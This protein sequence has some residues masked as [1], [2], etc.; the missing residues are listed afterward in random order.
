MYKKIFVLIF[1]LLISV[2]SLI[3]VQ[4]VVL[5]ENFTATWCPYCPSAYLGLANLK[6]QVRDSVTILAYHRS[7]AFTVPEVNVRYSYYSCTG[8]PT[9]LFDGVLRRVGGYSNQNQPMYYRDLYDSRQSVPAPIE[10]TL[11]RT[12]FNPFSGN[13]AVSVTINNVST[14]IIEGNL[15]CV[16]V[17]KETTYAWQN[18]SKL[19]DVVLGMFPNN[20]NGE[21]LSLN[22]GEQLLRSYNYSIPTA[23]REMSCAIVAFLQNNT[24]KE[25]YNACEVEARAGIE[26]THQELI[27]INTISFTNPVSKQAKF[28]FD[29]P[30]TQDLNLSIYDASG[31]IV[32]TLNNFLG[33]NEI[34]W[35]LTDARGR[36][37]KSGIYFVKCVQK[38]QKNI[39]KL[40]IAK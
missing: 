3:A 36:K 38:N 31:K 4:R 29:N 12:S 16:M 7:D 1:L 10:L 28:Y 2:T 22:P 35:D 26:E 13:G 32:K 27:S 15:R 18:Q 25:V 6:N 11:D 34:V 40:V 39:Y 23:W 17:G 19:Y 33:K 14:S 20:A 8:V 24:T 9:V 30:I 37:V 21:L 5:V